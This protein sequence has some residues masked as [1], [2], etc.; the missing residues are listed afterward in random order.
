MGKQ[1]QTLFS[2]KINANNDCSHD[3][4]RCL[5]IGRKT[6]TNLDSVFKSRNITLLKD[7]HLVKAMVFPGVT[8]ECESWTIKKAGRRRID[9]FELWCWRRLLRVPWT[10]RKS[11]QSSLKEINPEYS[12]EG[13]MLKLKFL[14]FGHLMH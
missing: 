5:L 11:N 2:S 14:Y 1:W 10:A 7:V 4:K 8:Y 12:L 9:A 3:I 13:L 6:M